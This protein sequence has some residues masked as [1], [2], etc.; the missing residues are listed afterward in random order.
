MKHVSGAFDTDII[1][2]SALVSYT[3]R[4]SSEAKTHSDYQKLLTDYKRRSEDFFTKWQ[5]ELNERN[6]FTLQAGRYHSTQKTPPKLTSFGTTEPPKFTDTSRKFISV[7]GSHLINLGILDKLSWQTSWQKTQ[8]EFS[9][10]INQPLGPIFAPIGQLIN[11]T[12]TSF[13]LKGYYG[14]IIADKVFNTATLEHNLSYGVDWGKED[15]EQIKSLFNSQTLFGT[16]TNSNR[17]QSYIPRS[18]R[19]NMGIFIRDRIHFGNTGFSITPSLKWQ[20]F[21]I[22]ADENSFDRLTDTSEEIYRTYKYTP[23]NVGLLFDWQ[24][25]PEHLLS[26]NLAQSTRVPSYTETNVADYFHWPAEP[27]PDLKPETARAISLAWQYH[28]DWLEQNITLSHTRYTDMIYMNMQYLQI[29]STD[30]MVRLENVPKTRVNALEYFAKVNFSWINERL[31]GLTLATNIAWAKGKDTHRNQPLNSISPL[32]GNVR[33]GYAT[34]HWDMFVRTNFAAKKKEK[35]IGSDPVYGGKVDPV[36]G[37]AT[38]DL[39]VKYEPSKAFNASLTL[40]NL[41]NKQYLRW[42]DVAGRNGSYRND[43]WQP[44]RAVG[45]DFAY[46]F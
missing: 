43:F 10:Y 45:I 6:H 5:W 12:G 21:K 44:G 37:Y 23:L 25:N 22:K 26:L 1:G 7:S 35:D 16:T 15:L 20:K 9:N 42:D 14:N 2:L 33:L 24:V 31:R 11:R 34:Q 17:E 38:V 13:N 36:A 28:N 29:T 46:R 40:Y 4:Q 18:K 41:F 39:G 32:E 27:N 3:H 19:N 30:W 8:T